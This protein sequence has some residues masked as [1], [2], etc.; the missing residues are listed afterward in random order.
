MWIESVEQVE[1]EP[2]N[3]VMLVARLVDIQ[4]ADGSPGSVRGQALTGRED[5]MV[6]EAA[7]VDTFRALGDAEFGHTV[8]F[9][10]QRV[11]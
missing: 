11:S 10:V 9:P 3:Q 2:I 7:D 5:S 1:D 4:P 8:S 6:Q